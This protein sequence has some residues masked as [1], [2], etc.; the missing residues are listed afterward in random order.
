[1]RINWSTSPIIHPMLTEIIERNKSKLAKSDSYLSPQIDQLIGLMRR[2]ESTATIDFYDSIQHRIFVKGEFLL[3]EGETCK[4]IW[5]IESGI[6]RQFINANGDEH[7]GRFYHPGEFIAAINRPSL[8]NIQFVNHASAFSLPHKC[9]ERFKITN[10]I[11]FEIEKLS[12]ECSA[13]WFERHN[14]LLHS[15]AIERYNFVL[16]YQ[17]IL[18]NSITLKN[19]ASYLK[20]SPERLSRIRADIKNIR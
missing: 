5:L 15:T 16:K 4:H 1:M 20:M 19:L 3:K 10:P 6:V 12:F 18:L 17:T 2:F 8:K 7:I 9:L 14:Y 11:L 13:S